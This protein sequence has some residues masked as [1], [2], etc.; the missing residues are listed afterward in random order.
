MIFNLKKQKPPISGKHFLAEHKPSRY[1]GIHM[2]VHNP[3][4]KK[5]L[6]RALAAKFRAF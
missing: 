2:N 3:H 1:R 5:S 4:I 6:N